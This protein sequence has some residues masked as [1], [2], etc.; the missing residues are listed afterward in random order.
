MKN[1]NEKPTQY[2]PKKKWKPILEKNNKIFS[3]QKKKMKIY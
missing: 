1:N 2:K 3:E